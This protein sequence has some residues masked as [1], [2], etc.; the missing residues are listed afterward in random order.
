[1]DHRNI[2]GDIGS[3]LDPETAPCNSDGSG[4]AFDRNC[5]SIT[6]GER[7][8]KVTVHTAAACSACGRIDFLSNKAK[9]LP[10]VLLVAES[11][12]IWRADKCCP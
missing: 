12:A 11:P 2:E 9:R 7:S 3:I 1:M 10:E 8:S 5:S 4:R 6:L